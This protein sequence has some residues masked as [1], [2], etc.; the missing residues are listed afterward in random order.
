MSVYHRKV[1]IYKVEGLLRWALQLKQ[2]ALWE[3]AAFYF[4]FKD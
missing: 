2:T 4:T 3:S 1:F